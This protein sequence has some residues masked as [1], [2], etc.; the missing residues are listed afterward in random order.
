MQ[1]DHPV[2]NSRHVLYEAQQ[3]HYYGLPAHLALSAVTSTPA[4]AVGL[5]HRIGL[6]Q[7]GDCNIVLEVK[8][9]ANQLF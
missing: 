1:S 5:Y 7:E 8:I 4:K 2:T 6:V 3:A 9:T